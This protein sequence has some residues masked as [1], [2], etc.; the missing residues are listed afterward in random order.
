M[1]H[2]FEP[3]DTQKLNKWKGVQNFVLLSP[4]VYKSGATAVYA[5]EDQTTKKLVAVKVYSGQWI[6]DN[7]SIVRNETDG[8][9]SLSV[10][11]LAPGNSG[12]FLKTPHNVY[13]PME[14]CNCGSLDKYIKKSPIPLDI[15]RDICKFIAESLKLMHSRKKLH[16]DVNPSHILVNVDEKNK[17]TYKLIGLQFHKHL[18]NGKT[19]SFDGT[20]AY[21]APE[22]TGNKEYTFSADIWGLG[23]TLYEM[24]YGCLPGA[25]DVNFVSKIKAGQPP[26]FPKDSKRTESLMNLIIR[27]LFYDPENRPT[28]AQI[29]DHP[30]SKGSATVPK[31]LVL[32][33]KEEKKVDSIA[34]TEASSEIETKGKKLSPEE[35]L[36]LVK[37]DFTSY[38]KYFIEAENKQRKLKAE[39][40]PSLDPYVKVKEDPIST[41]GFSEV[42]LCKHKETGE[43]VIL[44]VVLTSKMTDLKVASLLLGEVEIMIDLND[45]AFSIGLSDYFVYKNNLCLI[46]DYCN[47]GDLDNYVRQSIRERKKP[48][49]LEELRLIAWCVGCGLRDMHALSI[50]HRDIKPKNILLVKDAEGKVVD[51]KLCDYG[52]SRKVNEQCGFKASTILGTYDYF[53]PELYKIMDQMMS[54]DDD[55]PVDKYDEKV[56]VW[57][58]GVLLYFSLYGKTIMEPPGSKAKVMKNRLIS[59]YAVTDVPDTFIN[60]IKRCLE[61]DSNVRPK[62]QELLQDPF[63][64]TVSLTKR[65]K[66]TPYSQVKEIGSGTVSHIYEGT[67]GK[68]PCVLKT[69]PVTDRAPYEISTLCNLKGAKNIVRLYDYFIHKDL[70]YLVLD[71]YPAG[72]LETFIF[73]KEKKKQYLSFDQQL[74]IAFS[75]LQGINDIHKRQMIHRDIH[76]KN[77]LLK[78]DSSKINVTNAAIGDFGF[79]KT[80]I[81]GD[82]TTTKLGSYQSPEQ[83][84]PEY[85]RKHDSKTDIWSYG[86]LVYFIHFGL[87]A[88][89]FGGNKAVKLMKGEE[90]TYKKD[91][92]YISEELV[93]LIKKCLTPNPKERPSALDLMKLPIFKAFYNL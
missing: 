14:L 41:G 25:L 71:Y 64:V 9:K 73:E 1:K 21:K 2:F 58:Y 22:T 39:K 19:S 38:M 79:A 45:S 31:E 10:D 76:P 44:K 89:D 8:M 33:Q 69:F 85:Q 78:T 32:Q 92:V 18:E 62:F 72:N 52:L 47:G 63:F 40:R 60:V 77:I 91:R 55:T 37:S 7:E 6:Q 93:E 75:V 5:A 80:L 53:A 20:I 4:E 67:N 87:H 30:F 26:P 3:L 68:K 11:G 15:I 13:F 35:Q 23:L 34:P 42:Y 36:S 90:I 65:E 51:V 17:V 43:E 12:T 81:E 56:D 46:I 57:S 16:G 29:L 59:Y 50:L 54:G 70:V 27:C 28:A 86:L 83:V 49:P 66:L 82:V 24:T 61:F 48:L 74:F 88:T 84:L